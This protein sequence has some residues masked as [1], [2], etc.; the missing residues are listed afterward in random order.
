M[1]GIKEIA[2]HIESVRETQKITSAMYLIS[3]AKLRKAKSELEKTRPYFNYL[4]KEIK[5]IFRTVDHSNSKYFYP[6]K[7]MP[8]P[9][10]KFGYLIVTADKGLAGPYNQNV[11]NE[12][13]ALTSAHSDFKL[14][15]VGE[16]GRHYCN[17]NN[18]P[19]EKSF[20]YTAQNP[21]LERAREIA[22]ELL[23]CFISGEIEKIF[24][25]YTDFKSQVDIK[26]NSTRLLPFHTSQFITNAEEKNNLETFEFFPSCEEVLENS[27]RSY[28]AGFIYSILVDSFCC[29]QNA[30][31]TAMQS[32]NRNAEEILKDLTKKY[33]QTRHNQIT[34]EITEI[35]TAA[36]YQKLRKAAILKKI[37]EQ[38]G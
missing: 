28:I 27:V 36:K 16:Y 11:L 12:L 2:E 24:V 29:E 10:G 1:A 13:E 34:Q 30:R 14:F 35:S 20:L 23:D 6:D 22:D 26:V 18:I 33:N 15:V 7:D 4:K 5:H 17:T 3:S 19:I 21:T 9:N 25:I 31:M 32:A 38:G 8:Q 37:S